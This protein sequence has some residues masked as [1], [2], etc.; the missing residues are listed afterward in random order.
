MPH[1]TRQRTQIKIQKLGQL[2]TA[3]QHA[4]DTNT[5]VP[6]GKVPCTAQHY[7]EMAQ[8]TERDH[9][10]ACSG[11]HA[12]TMPHMRSPSPSRFSSNRL[13][14]VFTLIARICA[15]FTINE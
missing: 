3:L 15:A 11:S 13:V 12:A 14:D 4:F 6:P 5:A 9:V 7:A 8:Q 1:C 2:S 10:L